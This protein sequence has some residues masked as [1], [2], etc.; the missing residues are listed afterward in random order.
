MN[1]TVTD[2]RP[3]PSHRLGLRFANGETRVFDLT[4]Y[5]DLGVFR[6]LQAQAVFSRAQVVA[7]SVEWP[8][9]VDLSYDTL[10]LE[11][12]PTTSL[13]IEQTLPDA[14]SDR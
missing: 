8:G 14:S 9:G 1:P 13:S 4:P 3:L 5:L 7:G 2:V 12:R 6:K 10:Y 11:S